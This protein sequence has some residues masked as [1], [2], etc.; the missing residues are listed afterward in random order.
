MGFADLIVIALA[1]AGK[2][3]GTS[4]THVAETADGGWKPPQLVAGEVGFFLV[5]FE[6]AGL[7]GDEVKGEPGAFFGFGGEEFAGEVR[8]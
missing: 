1:K 7:V 4:A 8:N 6:V 3:V 5:E 2:L